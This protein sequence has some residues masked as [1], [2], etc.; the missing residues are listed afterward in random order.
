MLLDGLQLAR[1]ALSNSSAYSYWLL[2]RCWLR[3]VC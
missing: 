1:G 3:L 2:A